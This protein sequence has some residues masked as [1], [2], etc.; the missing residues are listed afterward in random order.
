MLPPPP[1]EHEV[2]R[3]KALVETQLLDSPPEAAFDSCVALAASICGTTKAAV[4]LVDRERQWFKAIFG[5]V[6]KE[7]QRDVSFCGHAV[8]HDDVL[9][10]PDATKDPRFADNPLVQQGLHFYAGVPL[11]GGD[12]LPLGTLCVF[13]DAPVSLTTRQ[14][15]QL[16]ELADGLQ[17]HLD[18]RLLALKLGARVA[19]QTRHAPVITATTAL[20]H[21]IRNPLATVHAG[22]SYLAQLDG[23]PDE[24]RQ[25]AED[26][27]SSADTARRLLVDL[28]DASR[29]DTRL[30]TTHF[31]EVD[32]RALTSRVIRP[33]R[34][35]ASDR[36]Q[37]LVLDDTAAEPFVVGD[38]LLIE[39]ALRN[40][41]DNA[42]KYGP[43]GRPITISIADGPGRS[44]ELRVADEGQTLPPSDRERIFEAYERA[45]STR[46]RDGHGIGLAFCRRAVALHQGRVWTEPR[47]GGGNVFVM[48]LPRK[49]PSAA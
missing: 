43:C 38:S 9:I 22:A 42:M 1:H 21:D 40:L 49:P 15:A 39:R 20:V 33:A 7:T 18:L 34:L 8:A 13:H 17:A 26:M 44:V 47:E 27:L 25:V 32:L 14:L 46:Q 6:P 31:A 48:Q 24:V 3:L 35:L 30:L 23:V 16:R 11:H 45:A 2:E 28:L 41:V 19:E 10:V 29:V 5:N 4:S 36:G 12:G 37:S